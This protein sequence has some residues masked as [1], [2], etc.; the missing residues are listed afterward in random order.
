MIKYR[1]KQDDSEYINLQIIEQSEDLYKLDG[2][3]IGSLYVYSISYPSFGACDH[4]L[5]LRGSGI[6]EDFKTII[7]PIKDI[8]EVVH[9]FD[10]L[11]KLYGD[12]GYDKV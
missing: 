6:S 7:I 10:L 4:V 3:V 8:Y 12:M 1:I 11:N 2:E 5:Y 9:T